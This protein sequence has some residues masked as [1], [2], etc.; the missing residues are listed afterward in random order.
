MAHQKLEITEIDNDKRFISLSDGRQYLF[1]DE[2]SGQLISSW[3][4]GIAVWIE[5]MY[6][7]SFR[8]AVL[9]GLS[10]GIAILAGDE[11][12]AVIGRAQEELDARN[13]RQRQIEAEVASWGEERSAA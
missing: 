11:A 12:N 6:R 8:W 13:T 9:A 7:R 10:T 3:R 5:A 2:A 4:P 1:D